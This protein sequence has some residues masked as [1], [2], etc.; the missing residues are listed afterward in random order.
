VELHLSRPPLAADRTNAINNL[1]ANTTDMLGGLWAITV[2]NIKRGADW[3]VPYHIGHVGALVK[4]ISLGDDIWGFFAPFTP[5]AWTFFFALVLGYGLFTYALEQGYNEDFPHTDDDRTKAGT[6]ITEM[7][8]HCTMFSLKDRDKPI[9]TSAGK[10]LTVFFSFV[11]IVVLS[12]YTA[13]LAAFMISASATEH[14]VKSQ[15]DLKS[16]R[17]SVLCGQST[18]RWV[19]ENNIA[20]TVVCA[21]SMEDAVNLVKKGSV[22]AAL[23]WVDELHY[24]AAE[25]CKVEVSSIAMHATEFSF[26]VARR[27]NVPSWRYRFNAALFKLRETGEFHKLR[28]KWFNIGKN[29]CGASGSETNPDKAQIK[30]T[31][32]IGLAIVLVGG[33]LVATF[34][35]VLKSAHADGKLKMPRGDLLKGE[36]DPE[37]NDASSEAAPAEEGSDAD[38]AAGLLKKSEDGPADSGEA[39]GGGEPTVAAS[40]P[41]T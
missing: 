5:L 1:A 12:S 39:A 4:R 40:E 20:K 36:A 30:L 31:N 21:H 41:T 6:V 32:I 33:L 19:K 27:D 14:F 38:E 34:V 28:Q 3:T 10:C 25:D 11:I 35:E 2:E 24:H 7:L 37:A 15:E 22:D 23:G 18:E 17:V 26:P 29:P 16:K 13:N 8:W 9:K